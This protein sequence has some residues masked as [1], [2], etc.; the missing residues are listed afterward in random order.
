MS[1]DNYVELSVVKYPYN[2]DARQMISEISPSDFVTLIS[3]QC[4]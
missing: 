3:N 2:S 4:L 1:E